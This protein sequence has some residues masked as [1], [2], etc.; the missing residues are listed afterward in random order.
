M[1]VWNAS[2]LGES[3]GLDYKTVNNYVDYLVGAFLV[4][5]LPHY[6]TNVRKR[7]VGSSRLYRRE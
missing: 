7:L 1:L 3:L 4:R 6:L 5:R 2:R